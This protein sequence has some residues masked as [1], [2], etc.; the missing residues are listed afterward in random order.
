MFDRRTQVSLVAV[1]MILTSACW[2]MTAGAN[3]PPPELFERGPNQIPKIKPKQALRT[4]TMPMTVVRGDAKETRIKIP[5]NLLGKG[6]NKLGLVAPASSKVSVQSTR[7]NTGPLG[8][9]V[10]GIAFSLAM[11]FAFVV[12]VKRLSANKLVV[13]TATILIAAIC[14]VGGATADF[15]LPGGQGNTGDNR[16]RPDLDS[17][18]PDPFAKKTEDAAKQKI[19]EHKIIVEIVRDGKAVELVLGAD[20]TWAK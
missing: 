2:A 12:L 5:V 9:V 16:P 19:A 6:N 18:V 13:T 4:A 3:A 1:L 11:G 15:P 10:A 7:P 8:T 20:A 14:F 17:I